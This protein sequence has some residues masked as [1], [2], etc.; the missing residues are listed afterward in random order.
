MIGSLTGRVALIRH[1]QVLILVSGVGY[2]VDL[3]LSDCSNLTLGQD[4]TIYTHL[5]VREDAHLLFGFLTIES[6]DSFRTLTKVSGVGPKIGLA[7]LSTLSLEE[8]QFAL[9][10]GSVDTLCKTPGIGKKVAERM[11]LELKGKFIFGSDF[12]TDKHTGQQL[13][14]EHDIKSDIANALGSL[15]Y[16]DKEIMRAIKALPSGITDLSEGIKEALK[17]LNKF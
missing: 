17:L 16:N 11:L 8:L 12:T 4:V 3:P 1:P 6:R 2:E 13:I 15:G 10:S 14:A 5:V 7:L 9:S